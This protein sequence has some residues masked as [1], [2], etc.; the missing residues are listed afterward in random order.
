VSAL[1]EMGFFRGTAESHIANCT[2]RSLCIYIYARARAPR[3]VR[4]LSDCLLTSNAV[5][6]AAAAS[7]CSAATFGMSAETLAANVTLSNG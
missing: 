6:T 4:A 7:N 5:S 2:N 3:D 1:R